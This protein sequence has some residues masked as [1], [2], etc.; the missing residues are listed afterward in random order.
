M[1]VL[2]INDL[3][4]V[5]L[6][7]LGVFDKLMAANALHLQRE[8]EKNRIRGPE[9]STV[10]LGS[11]T[12]VL[13]AAIAFLLAKDKSS[14][15]LQILA[16][17]LQIA[18]VELLKANVELQ[19]M[20]ANLLKVPA[21][22]ALLTAQKDVAVQQVS[23]MQDDLLTNAKQRNKIDQEIL[24]AIKQEV[25]IDKQILDL[26]RKTA[27]A[28]I[29]GTVLVAQE[30]KLRAEFD[31]TIESKLKT[32][33]ETLLLSQKVTTERAQVS[34]TGVDE[35]SVVG[36]QKALYTAQT[37]GFR[38]DAKQKAAKM[39]ADTWSTRRM[40]LDTTEANGTNKLDDFAIGTAVQSMLDDVAT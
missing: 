33:Q 22:I 6:D 28:V 36:K 29:E 27:N 19:I 25:V 13:N 21:E 35:D 26:V 4:E 11:L 23:N 8:F 34:A 37:R 9:Y 31:L 15:E 18:Q 38:S 40:T 12:N 32:A 7:G 24:I 20:Q 2:T 17:Q 39:M 14:I 10:Y 30:C 5:K 1:T 16:V 3:T